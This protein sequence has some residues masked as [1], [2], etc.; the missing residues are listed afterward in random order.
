MNTRCDYEGGGGINVGPGGVGGDIWY[1]KKDCGSKDCKN[2]GSY[3]GDR[4]CYHIETQVLVADRGLTKLKDVQ[5]GDMVL[6]LNPETETTEFTKVISFFH[7]DNGKEEF[8]Y[9]AI[10]IDDVEL[11]LTPN[12][13]VITESGEKL[14]EH[15]VTGDKLLRISD[16]GKPYYCACEV[17]GPMKARGAIDP[18]TKHMNIVTE[19]NIVGS[20]YTSNMSLLKHLE[21]ALPNCGKTLYTAAKMIGNLLPSMHV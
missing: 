18:I 2:S 13:Y 4:G 12:H 17:V 1:K 5:V 8:T 3:T 21:L 9:L 19:G 6:A 14:A 10:R 16:Q 11:R 15:L 20:C 7:N